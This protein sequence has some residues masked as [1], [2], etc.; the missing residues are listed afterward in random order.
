MPVDTTEPEQTLLVFRV[1]EHHCAIAVFFVQ[2]ILPMMS[3]LRPPGT[4]GIVE[5]FLNLRGLAVPAV[6]LR[7]LFRLPPASFDLY[8]PLIVVRVETQVIAFIA[9]ATEDVARVPHSCLSAVPQ[10]HVMNSCARASYESD[11]GSVTVLSPRQLLLAREQAVLSELTSEIQ[12]RL[13]EL[14]IS[15]V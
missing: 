12:Q 15:G 3:M 11:T 4:P 8:T 5:G 10:D 2:E 6:S 13:G 9:D 7:R 1:A 14:E